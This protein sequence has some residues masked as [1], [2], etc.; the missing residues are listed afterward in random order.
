RNLRSGRRS[1]DVSSSAEP[2]AHECLPARVPEVGED[3][4]VDRIPLL[5]PACDGSR[6]GARR[7]GGRHALAGEADGPI[8]GRPAEHAREE[9]LLTS[10]ACRPSSIGMKCDT[11]A[12]PS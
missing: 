3:V 4:L 12:T 11:S 10:C 6:E 9:K 1:A 5:V 8:N 2:L 7:G